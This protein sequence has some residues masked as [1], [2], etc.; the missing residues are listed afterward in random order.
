[1]KTKII[2]IVVMLMMAVNAMA[3]DYLTV[4]FKDGKTE[5]FY[6][7]AVNKFYTS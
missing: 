2:S 4:F 7:R 1:M 6:M 5:S 3:Q